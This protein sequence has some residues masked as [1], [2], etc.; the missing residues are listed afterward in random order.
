MRITS[1]KF[2]S[3]LALTIFLCFSLSCQKQNENLTVEEKMILGFFIDSIHFRNK[4]MALLQEIPSTSFEEAFSPKNLKKIDTAMSLMNKSIS[5]SVKV[6]DQ[7]LNMLHPE[8][9]RHFREEFCEGL[10]LYIN[11]LNEGD[12]LKEEKAELLMDNWGRWFIEEF[13]AMCR[14]NEWFLSEFE[15]RQDEILVP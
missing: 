2:A 11:F 7:I 15:K 10:K 9:S 14:K 5:R 1:L 3:I 8:L 13:D 12:T 4:A 6:N